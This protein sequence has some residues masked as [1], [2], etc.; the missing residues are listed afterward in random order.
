[1]FSR[2]IGQEFLKQ[3]ITSLKNC[4]ELRKIYNIKFTGHQGYASFS[5]YLDKYCLKDKCK[6]TWKD[7]LIK[8]DNY[9]NSFHI[10]FETY[11]KTRDKDGRVLSYEEI[12]K[13]YSLHKNRKPFIYLAG[14]L[15]FECDCYKPNEPCDHYTYYLGSDWQNIFNNLK[16]KTRFWFHNLSYDGN[17]LIPELF[18]NCGYKIITKTQLLDFNKPWK[19]ILKKEPNRKPEF[20]KARKEF[21]TGTLNIVSDKKKIY[22]ITG[23]NFKGTEF[24]IECSL[25][26]LMGSVSSLGKSLGYEKLEDYDYTGQRY[27]STNPKINKITDREIYY[28]YR[29]MKIPQMF[30]RHIE[31]NVKKATG[32]NYNWEMTIG[33]AAV[34]FFKKMFKG[35]NEE[36]SFNVKYPS[37]TRNQYTLHKLTYHGGVA[38]FNMLYQG[39]IINNVSGF[40]INSSYP[41]KMKNYKTPY[42]KSMI[43]KDTYVLYENSKYVNCDINYTDIM[44]DINNYSN[45]SNFYKVFKVSYSNAI[46]KNIKGIE[47]FVQ[48]AKQDDGI[49]YV[50]S[51]SGFNYMNQYD[52]TIFLRQFDITDLK[53]ELVYFFKHHKSQQMK[54]YVEFWHKLKTYF[55]TSNNGNKDKPS[56]DFAKFMLNALSGKM[57]Q[58]PIEQETIWD[59]ENEDVFYGEIVEENKCKPVDV[60]AAITALGRLQL[61]SLIE[62]VGWEKWDTGDT[63]SGKFINIPAKFLTKKAK[64]FNIAKEKM[65]RMYK[66]DGENELGYWSYEWTAEKFEVIGKK[67]SHRIVDGEYKVTCNGLKQ[68]QQKLLC[69]RDDKDSINKGKL[70]FMIG[71]TIASDELLKTRYIKM[72]PVLVPTEFN[73]KQI[74]SGQ[75]KHI[76]VTPSLPTWLRQEAM[77]IQSETMTKENYKFTYTPTQHDFENSNRKYE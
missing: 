62:E 76:L 2:K 45:N 25:R 64:Y 49:N 13:Y 7:H 18:E 74:L 39:K 56:Y 65:T 59:I 68:T 70:P 54:R 38:N 28:H 16:H 34:K 32:N 72:R 55:A 58:E 11:S 36:K 73:M 33:I 1:M 19:K 35:V 23:Y 43:I 15:S 20:Y 60:I 6:T 24:N 26:K 10:D 63:D 37:L 9:K 75:I 57:G 12:K 22:K 29:D 21:L 66:K 67:K 40:D 47:P 41:D 42:G 52:L 4:V 53:I 8:W 48:L 31:D 14:T 77:R 61:L 71:M 5:T 17:F 50:Y 27:N 30:K 46:I 3:K 51:H 44:K 69:F